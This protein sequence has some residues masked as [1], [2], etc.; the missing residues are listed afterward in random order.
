L[1][2]SAAVTVIGNAAWW[3]ITALGHHVHIV[4]R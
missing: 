4:V 3:T 2:V 1:L